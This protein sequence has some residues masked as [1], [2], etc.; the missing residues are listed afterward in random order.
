VVTTSSA[1]KGQAAL[2]WA[3]TQVGKPYIWGAAGPNGYDCSGLTMKA[4]ASVGISI[5]RTT[6]SQ[7]ANVA[8]VPISQMRPGDLIF[9]SSNGA[10][11]GIYHVAIYAGNNMRVHAPSPGKYVEY[12]K[13][14]WTNVLPYVGRP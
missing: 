4:Y 14:Y 9:Y 2:A 12:V 3:L 5:G 10:A 1:S 6:K 11:S 8:H 13:M 7:Y